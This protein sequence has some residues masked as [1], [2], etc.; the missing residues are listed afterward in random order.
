MIITK[1]V[2]ADFSVVGGRG[3]E[4]VVGGQWSGVGGWGSV[5]SGRWLVVSVLILCIIITIVAIIMFIMYVSGFL[6]QR[7]HGI[8]GFDSLCN[9][10]FL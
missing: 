6:I 4:V 1:S 7:N 10:Q 9:S 8:S 3:S 5:V 2:E